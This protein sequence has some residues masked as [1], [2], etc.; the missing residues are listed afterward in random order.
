MNKKIIKALTFMLLLCM[1]PISLFACANEETAESLPSDSGTVNNTVP[2]EKESTND[3]KE[4]DKAGTITLFK[5]GNYVAKIIRADNASSTDMTLYSRI[6]AAFKA[7]TGKTVSNATDFVAQG[8][9]LDDSAAIL[10]GETAYEESKSVYESL[11]EGTAVAKIINNKYV[12]AYKN[13][14]SLQKLLTALEAKIAS[15]SAEE[16]VIDSSWELK[17]ESVKLVES[18]K[19]PDYN[20]KPLG[21]AIDIGQASEL[22][23]IDNTTL[24]EYN[25]YLKD[26]EG[27]GFKTYTSNTIGNNQFKTY[28]T[29]T[30]IVNVMFLANANQVRVTQDSRDAIELPALKATNIYTKT[31]TPSFTMMGISDSGYPGG[32]SFIYKL[33]DG[34]FFIID[35]GICK[36]RGVNDNESNECSGEPSVHRLYKTLRELAD[37]PD[38]IVISGWLITHIHNDHAGSFIDLADETAYLKNITIKQVIYSQPSDDDMSYNK[39]GRRNNWMPN[40]LNKM[41]I[42]KTVKAHPGQVFYYADLTLTIIGTHDLVKPKSLNSH[43]NASIV[44]FVEFG[45]KKALYLADAEGDANAQLKALYG[46][47]LKADIVQ[48]AHHGYNNTNANIVYAYVNPTIVLWPIQTADYKSGDNVYNLSLNKQYFNKS[49]ISNYCAGDA[50]TTFE[51]LTTWAPTKTNWKPA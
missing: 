38:K 1:L 48:V 40:A 2:T 34:T 13:N 8:E 46:E 17:A 37:D 16:I 28:I 6:R 20:G 36:N 9:K 41:K 5:N 29:D 45:G 4:T 15:A 50:N 19:L 51:N 43:N 25:A 12:V 3:M 30:Q 39:G 33:S 35:G 26:L 49:G 18:V 21:T 7:K 42:E 23:I 31:S 24:L 27:L 22:Y 44:S 47:N 11:E 14:E 32:M 10:V